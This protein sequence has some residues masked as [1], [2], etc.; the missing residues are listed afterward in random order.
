[1][2]K[3]ITYDEPYFDPNTRKYD[4]SET[5]TFTVYAATADEYAAHMAEITDPTREIPQESIRVEDLPPTADGLK[6]ELAATD[7]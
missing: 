2:N 3:Q 1:M 6:A 5:T 4:H 7:Y